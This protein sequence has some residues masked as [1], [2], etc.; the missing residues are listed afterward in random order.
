[1]YFVFSDL[2]QNL[3]DTIAKCF[4]TVEMKF[5]NVSYN[6]RDVFVEGFCKYS[7]TFVRRCILYFGNVSR[8]LI[9]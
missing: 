5:Q 4:L 3:S 8:I 6:T 2:F 9:S 1:M 7:N